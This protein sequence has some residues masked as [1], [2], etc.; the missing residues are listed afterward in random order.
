MNSKFLDVP[1][2]EAGNQK[3]KLRNPE[4]E[5]SEVVGTITDPIIAWPSPWMADI[6]EKVKEQI[7]IQR[8]IM[9]IMYLNGKIPR[10][11]GTDAEALA[12]MFPRTMEAPIDRDWVDIYVYL[13]NQLAKATGTEFPDDMKMEILPEYLQK[14]LDHLKHWIYE[15]RVAARRDRD[16]A[17]RRE[18]KEAEETQRKEVQP[19]LFEF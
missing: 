12:Y 14:K 3:P 17:G 19:V 5:I 4:E 10:P 18:Q 13:G 16:R 2:E 6:P 11:T 9:Y 15:K 7:P 8:M 1:T